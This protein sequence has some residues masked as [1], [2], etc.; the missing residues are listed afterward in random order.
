MSCDQPTCTYWCIWDK[1]C[2]S[3]HFQCWIVLY[4]SN[5]EYNYN[6]TLVLEL[7]PFTKKLQCHSRRHWQPKDARLLCPRASCHFAQDPY[8]CR[9]FMDSTVVHHPVLEIRPAC[10]H[11]ACWATVLPCFAHLP[12]CSPGSTS[13]KYSK[14]CMTACNVGKG[15]CTRVSVIEWQHAWGTASLWHSGAQ[16]PISW[17]CNAIAEQLSTIYTWG[18]KHA[19]QHWQGTCRYFDLVWIHLTAHWLSEPAL[20]SGESFTMHLCCQVDAKPQVCHMSGPLVLS[21]WLLAHSLQEGVKSTW[22]P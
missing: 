4:T 9:V 22:C 14:L 6:S 11:V 8:D 20:N 7:L 21:S 19:C 18:W 16:M 17:M 15:Q 2:G 1:L 5:A 12:L 10:G 3:A 13:S